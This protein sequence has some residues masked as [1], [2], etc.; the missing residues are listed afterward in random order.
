MSVTL[1]YRAPYSSAPT[2]VQQH[3]KPKNLVIATVLAGAASDAQVIITHDFGLTSQD[4]A[5][6]YPL[7]TI[8]PED[9]NSITSPWFEAS[10]AHDYTVLGKSTVDVGGQ[11]K[12]GISRPPT[13]IR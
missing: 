10:Q 11:V 12:V 13:S 3:Y 4:L 6:G 7:V 2:L 8:T 9:G 1:T 5:M